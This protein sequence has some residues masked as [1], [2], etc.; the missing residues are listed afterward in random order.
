MFSENLREP[1]SELWPLA[2]PI[3]LP[4][5]FTCNMPKFLQCTHLNCVLRARALLATSFIHLTEHVPRALS[6]I[7][8]LSPCC[9]LQPSTMSVYVGHSVSRWTLHPCGR[10]ERGSGLLASDCSHLGSESLD[11]RY[12]SLCL[13]LSKYL[14]F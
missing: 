9:T 11:G 12:S 3:F 8:E 6:L 4:Y 7:S 2:W 1:L 13:F 10:P 5:A 14:T